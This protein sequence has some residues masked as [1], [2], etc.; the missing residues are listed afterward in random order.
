[1]I[2][3]TRRL[4]L[5]GIAMVAAMAPIAVRAQAP[6]VAAPDTTT[7]PGT[8]RQGNFRVSLGAGFAVRPDYAG[9]RSMVAM[10]LPLVDVR[11]RDTLFLSTAGG[12]PSIGANL[13]NA[14]GWRAGPVLRLRF[15]RE[16]K[17]NAVLRGMGDIGWAP[18]IGAFVEY[19]VGLVRL[20]AEVRH[21]TG[22][23]DGLVGEVRADAVLRPI[24]GM[25]LS[26]GP[27]LNLGNDSFTR[28]YFGVDTQQAARTG[29]APYRPGGG[30]TSAGVGV[31]ASYALTSNWSVAAIVEFNRLLGGA[32]DSPLVRGGRGNPNQ[33]FGALS[34]TYSF[35]L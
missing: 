15:P 13:I 25:V 18:E 4:G 14:N 19:R 27:R 21:G 30:L 5:A 17:T 33:V 24:N 32:A 34:L 16:Q 2:R 12:L 35:G 9:S 1:M 26:F 28:R 23:H 31:F 10:P 6:S 11:W 7:E 8:V 22:G 3:R 20:G 29:Y